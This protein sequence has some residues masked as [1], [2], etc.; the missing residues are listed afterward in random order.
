MKKLL[1]IFKDLQ[2]LILFSY[3]ALTAVLRWQLSWEVLFWFLGGVFGWVIV[4][5]DRLVWIYWT[6]PQ[7][8]LSV[9]FRYLIGLKKFKQAGRL[10]A[11]RKQEQTELTFRSAV[12]QIIWLILALFT[13]T[14]SPSIFS[15]GLVLGLG[16]HLLYD[17]WKD[18]CQSPEKLRSWLFW[19]IKRPVSL[20]EQRLF[21]IFVSAFFVFLNWLLV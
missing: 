10:L 13:I 12:F 16:L 21:L 8:Q 11:N 18:Y 17:E 14:S 4:V 5:V 2:V 19:Q 9:Q 7:T 15:R 6:R 3:L 20:S 1:N